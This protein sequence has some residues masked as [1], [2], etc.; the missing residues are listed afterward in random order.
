M[1]MGN[2]ACNG[3]VIDYKDLK[4]LC[5]KQIKAIEKG[6]YFDRLGWKTLAQGVEFDDEDTIAD[7]F[8]AFGDE[9]EVSEKEA[10][11]LA[12][13]YVSLVK[14]LYAAFNVRTNGLT[15]YLSVYDEEGGGRYD[16]VAIEDGCIFCVDGMVDYTPA[17]K[18]FKHIIRE[19]RWVQWG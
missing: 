3:F 6:K 15:L 5:P 19:S 10:Y 11:E 8:Y 17:G 1:G 14:D 9:P 12:K 7:A 16:T 4:K 18:E 2:F 13:Q